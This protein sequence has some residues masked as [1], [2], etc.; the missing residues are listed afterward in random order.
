LNNK[1]KF[2]RFASSKSISAISI[3]EESIL[4]RSVNSQMK[5]AATILGYPV[6]TRVYIYITVL[7]I[8]YYCIIMITTWLLFILI[9]ILLLPLSHCCRRWNRRY[10]II[11]YYLL[12]LSRNTRRIRVRRYSDFQNDTTRGS[13]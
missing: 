13:N 12:S 1:V 10:T 5:K 3:I 11:T 7:I 9:I 8:W 2:S 4:N 6:Y